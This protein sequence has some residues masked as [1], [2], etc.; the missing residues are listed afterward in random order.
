MSGKRVTRPIPALAATMPAGS[1]PPAPT[2]GRCLLGVRLLWL[3]GTALALA[4]VVAAIP[5]GYEQIQLVCVAQPCPDYQLTAED[6]REWAARGITPRALAAYDILVGVG[7]RAVVCFGIAAAI[8]RRRFD[9]ERALLV[10]LL[11]VLLGANGAA[12]FLSDTPTI[13]RG[14]AALVQAL[15]ESGLVLFCYLFPDGRFAPRW[16][17]WPAALAV[18]LTLLEQIFPGTGLDPN[19]WP[20]PL[21]ALCAAFVLGGMLAA[22]VYR[23]RHVSGPLERQQTKWVI[24]GVAAAVGTLLII[25]LLNALFPSLGRAGTLADELGGTAIGVSL[26]LIPVAIGVAVLRYRLFDIDILIGRT[27]VYGTLTASVIGLY[28]LVV[29]GLGALFRA[30]GSPI[31]ALIATGVVATIFQPLRWR[32]QRGV[33]RLLYGERDDPYTI[34]SRLGQRLESTLA[35]DAVLPALVGEVRAA[36]R[37]PYAAISLIDGEGESIAAVSGTP[38]EA[39]LRLPLTYQHEPVGELRLALRAPGEEFNADD[40]R[41]LDDLARQAGIAAHAVRLTADLQRSRQRLVTAREEERRRL[42]RDLHDGLGPQLAGF[43]LRLD[44]ARNLLRRDPDAADR[45]LD[46][47]IAR[48]QEAVNDIRRLVYALRPPALDDLGLVGALRR[49]AAQYDGG[50]LHVTVDA[51][52]ALPPLPAAVEVAAYRIAQEA[53]ANVARHAGARRCTLRLELD[54]AEALCLEIGDDGRG[55]P[56][57]R[58]AGVGLTSMRERAAELGGSCAIGTTAGG[59]TRVRARLPL[60]GAAGTLRQEAGGG[61][62]DGW[63][64]G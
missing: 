62:P 35:P 30:H 56:A 1:A 58:E 57:T 17:R 28:A 5:Y 13:W 51:A 49:A 40:R 7:L 45:V 3:I 15:I 46:D 53:L 2:P 16:A 44:A 20:F 23:Y 54:G 19:E 32:L 55:I 12:D 9:D 60:R 10:A 31:V 50:G 48:T 6:A 4:L 18:G 22:Q 39:P 52:G 61:E 8:A 25:L 33:N 41:L 37:L 11:I 26:L 24:F 34:L 47:L 59:G 38:T 43:T 64:G 29:G 63:T 42:R 27:L 14:A 21:N 36:L